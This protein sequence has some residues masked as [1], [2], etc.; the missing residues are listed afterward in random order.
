MN[1]ALSAIAR[2]YLWLS[3]KSYE[4]K[5]YYYSGSY[6]IGLAAIR[7]LLLANGLLSERDRDTL[8]M[9]YAPGDSGG[10]PSWADLRHLL[11]TLYDDCTR[12]LLMADFHRRQ[13]EWSVKMSEAFF[14]EFPVERLPE[15][16][17]LFA[18]YCDTPCSSL[19]VLDNE[20]LERYRQDTAALLA[21]RLAGPLPGDG[22]KV[23]VPFADLEFDMNDID[24]Y[25]VDGLCN[26]YLPDRIGGEDPG[27]EFA[28]IFGAS[29]SDDYAGCI[30]ADT[31]LLVEN[32]Y[33]G[34]LA[35]IAGAGVPA[36]G[37]ALRLAAAKAP[38]VP[39]PSW[40]WTLPI[41]GIPIALPEPVP[42][43]ER[44][45]YYY[46]MAEM[47]APVLGCYFDYGTVDN[48]YRAL[49]HQQ[50]RPCDKLVL[51]GHVERTDAMLV[52]YCL[53]KLIF[54]DE[55]G[56]DAPENG[57]YRTAYPGAADAW[58]AGFLERTIMPASDNRRDNDPWKSFKSRE[59]EI[60]YNL[61]S[62]KPSDGVKSLKAAILGAARELR[63][64]NG[65]T[66]DWEEA[67]PIRRRSPKTSGNR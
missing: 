39:A 1:N 56:K 46:R 66:I 53:A 67:L 15:D 28:V 52:V 20:A 9:F 47:L 49:C 25:F 29:H 13:K 12:D 2:A 55:P 18:L 6:R 38:A 62:V 40:Y 32:A 8:D 14:V 48:L 23:F 57:R 63:H 58:I 10:S 26:Y 36:V 65:I 51:K 7:H 5:G 43:S 64:N 41:G 60:M 54:N 37:E 30:W 61:C 35:D 44:D 3:T 16:L 17:Q 34:V 50:G 45:P 27:N 59:A 24:G 31:I 42:E 33:Q 11:A 4:E 19:S 22:A 21:R